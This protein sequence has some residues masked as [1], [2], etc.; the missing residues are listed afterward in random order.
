MPAEKIENCPADMR[1]PCALAN[2]LEI[3]GDRWTLLVIRDLMFTNRREFGHFL[4]AGEGIST[5]ILTERLERLQQSGV[6]SKKPHPGHGK[7]FIYELTERGINLAPVLIELA[8]WA[9]DNIEGTFIPPVARSM[10][11]NNRELLLEK[12]RSREP[13]VEL[14]L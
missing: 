6:I 5:N 11:L 10:M 1:S 3:L 8:L 12:I 14:N 9:Y 4:N 13:L 7:K 2:G